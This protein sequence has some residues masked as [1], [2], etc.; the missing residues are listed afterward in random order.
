CGGGR[1]GDGGRGKGEG[2]NAEKKASALMAQADRMRYKATLSKTALNMER[3]A[4]RLLAGLPEARRADRVARLRLPEPSPCG[5]L[6]LTARSLSKGYGSTEVFTGIDL[7]VERGSRT[8]ILCVDGA[9]KTTPL[10]L[11]AR[12]QH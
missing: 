6:P 5:R 8:L 12:L 7:D 1:E 11:P 9:G 10:R 2:A 3:R 4:E